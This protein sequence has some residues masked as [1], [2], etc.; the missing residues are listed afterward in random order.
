MSAEGF[1]A[2]EL[3]RGADRLVEET[4]KDDDAEFEGLPTIRKRL[5][6]A[7]AEQTFAE[8]QTP[9]GLA[10]PRELKDLRRWLTAVASSDDTD[11]APDERMLATAGAWI[12]WRAE[13]D[14]DT[15]ELVRFIASYLLRSYAATAAD[16]LRPEFGVFDAEGKRVAAEPEPVQ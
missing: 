6:L 14:P 3:R 13:K 11:D 1:S 15:L 12:A 7:L 2:A 10:Y 8:G 9:R 16:I 5:L 4:Q